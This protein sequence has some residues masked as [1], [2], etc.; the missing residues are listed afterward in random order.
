MPSSTNWTQQFLLTPTEMAEV[1]QVDCDILQSVEAAES[2]RVEI[3]DYLRDLIPC[4]SVPVQWGIKTWFS[5][6]CIHDDIPGFYFLALLFEPLFRLTLHSAGRPILQRS[7]STDETGSLYRIQY[8]ML[9]S[10]GLLSPDNIAWLVEHLD[11]AEKPI[12]ERVLLLA[13]KCR[14][15]VA[16]GAITDFSEEIR[17]TYG[18]MLIKA[19]QLVV[20]AGRR[21]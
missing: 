1:N 16:H 2:W 11:A 15:A 21:K 18:H 7:M 5:N 19:I 3:R 14:D 20:E 13:M 8:L 17:I 12:A 9:D 10:R 4:I 6:R